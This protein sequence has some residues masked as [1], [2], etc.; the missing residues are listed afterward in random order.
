MRDLFLG[1]AQILRDVCGKLMALHKD[2][3]NVDYA[4][5]DLEIV[6]NDLADKAKYYDIDFKAEELDEMEQEASADCGCNFPKVSRSQINYVSF[7][8]PSST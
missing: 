6:A 8:F 4:L 2:S 3:E 1:R 5:E 7:V